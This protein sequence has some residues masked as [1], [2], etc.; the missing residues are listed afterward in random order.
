MNTAKKKFS[1][2]YKE[3]EINIPYDNVLAIEKN[4]QELIDSAIL[5]G[6]KRKQS[7]GFV[8][9]SADIQSDNK[10]TGSP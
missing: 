2:T 8:T 6:S 5:L 9:T 10:I 3:I 7:E 1:F 4:R